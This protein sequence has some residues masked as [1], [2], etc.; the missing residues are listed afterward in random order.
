M[1]GVVDAVAAAR[2][3]VQQADRLLAERLRFMPVEGTAERMRPADEAEWQSIA[4][5]AIRLLDRATVALRGALA[6]G[7]SAE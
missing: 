3:C 6:S 2:V 5:Q 4:E 1:P 7:S